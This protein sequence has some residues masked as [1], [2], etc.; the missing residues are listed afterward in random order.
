MS[1]V[2]WYCYT[3]TDRLSFVDEQQLETSAFMLNNSDSGENH[4]VHPSDDYMFHFGELP[5]QTLLIT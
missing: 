2:V 1:L 4:Y 3:N 5:A